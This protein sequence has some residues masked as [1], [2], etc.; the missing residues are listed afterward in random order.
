MNRNISTDEHA[1]YT[2]AMTVAMELQ[3]E[4]YGDIF[5]DWMG[6]FAELEIRIYWG[7]WSPSAER[8]LLNIR[9]NMPADQREQAYNDFFDEIDQHKQTVNSKK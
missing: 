4:G 5:I 1:M 6:H 2:S 8:T 9:G 3:L 7:K